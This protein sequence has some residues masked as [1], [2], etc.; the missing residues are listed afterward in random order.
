[1][2]FKDVKD[3]TEKELIKKL[4]TLKKENFELKMKNSLGQL[5]N[6]LVIRKGRRDL[7]RIKTALASKH[8]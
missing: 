1:M 3:L 5:S 6:P 2:N 4:N 8:R 7:A